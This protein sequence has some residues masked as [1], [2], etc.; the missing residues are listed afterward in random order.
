MKKLYAYTG[1]VSSFSYRRN[2]PNALPFADLVPC[3]MADDNKAPVRI[4]AMGGLAD[5]IREIEGTDAEERYL[6]AV[7]FYDSLLCLHRI[8]IPSTDPT[9]PAKVIA[10]H[11][12]ISPTCSVFGPAEY[13][14]DPKPQPLA[15]DQNSAWLAF[16]AADDYRA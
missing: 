9:T 6:P 1:T 13:I 15:A 3:D 10:Q 8:E 14:E 12:A 7:W 2:N 11:D 4:E 16:Y 5:Y